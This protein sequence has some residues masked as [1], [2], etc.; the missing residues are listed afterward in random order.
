MVMEISEVSYTVS[1]RLMTYNHA[2]YIRQAMTGILMQTVD[3]NVEVVVGDDFSTDGTLDIIR[4][5]KST[6][7]I[8]IKILERQVGDAYWSE[9]QKQGRLFNFVDIVNHCSGKY[10]ALLDGDDY[11]VDPNKLRRQ[12]EFLE[13]NPDYAVCYHNTEERYEDE[14]NPSFLYVP[15]NQ[16]ITSGIYDLAIGNFMPSCSVLARNNGIP[17]WISKAKVGDW[18][19]NIHCS[20]F[21][22][23]NYLPQVMGVHRIHSGSVWS[24]NGQVENVNQILATYDL[25]NEVYSS[26]AELLKKLNTGRERLVNPPKRN[27]KKRNQLVKAVKRVFGLK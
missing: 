13:T 15:I 8:H 9:R 24:L 12:V 19:F 23:I 17:G 10:V 16:P 3:F 2:H 27:T 18:P 7:K 4:E 21:G 1:V 6:D 14:K 22:K 11:W 25:L 26:E 5:F 20:S